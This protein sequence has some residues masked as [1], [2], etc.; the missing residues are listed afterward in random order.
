MKRRVLTSVSVRVP[1]VGIEAAQ[2][3][4]GR[5]DVRAR[6]EARHRVGD[7]RGVLRDQ[8]HDVAG[9]DDPEVG[10]LLAPNTVEGVGSLKPPARW[11][12]CR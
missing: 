2:V 5:A 6:R 11:M 3:G 4:V 7:H 9:V 10:D 8:L 12:R 1:S